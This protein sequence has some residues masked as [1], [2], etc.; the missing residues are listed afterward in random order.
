MRGPGEQWD[1]TAG[2][3][4]VGTQAT[5]NGL[6]GIKALSRRPS[7]LTEASQLAL[8]GTP[9]SGAPHLQSQVSLGQEQ[10]CRLQQGHLQQDF[11]LH[12]P[13]LGEAQPIQAPPVLAMHLQ[14]L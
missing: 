5:W 10:P 14:D 9:G 6:P 2:R 4:A 3:V 1:R 13:Q 11:S 8:P 12:H 7:S